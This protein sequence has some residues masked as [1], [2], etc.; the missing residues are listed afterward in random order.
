MGLQ[1]LMVWTDSTSSLHVLQCC[2]GASVWRLANLLPWLSLSCCTMLCCCDCYLQGR[3]PGFV[4]MWPSRAITVRLLARCYQ[5]TFLLR[6]TECTGSC[7]S[8]DTL[9]R[10]GMALCMFC[11]NR[12]P[13]TPNTT[14]MSVCQLWARPLWDVLRHCHHCGDISC[15]A[16]DRETYWMELDCPAQDPG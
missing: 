12:Q 6:V 2:T 9:G 16:R 1:Q 11:L 14:L 7:L 10:Q 13:P 3:P 15:L 5:C 8:C 4:G